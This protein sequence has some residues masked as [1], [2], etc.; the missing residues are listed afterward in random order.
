MT[1]GNGL[2]CV[3]TRH[4]ASYSPDSACP[5]QPWMFSP[6]GQ[7]WLHG[8]RR[9]RYTGR[10]VR[11]VPVWLARLEPGSSVM[12]KGLRIDE[13]VL[14]DVAI[15]HLL[16]AGNGLGVERWSKQM[17]KAAL[18]LEVRLD[19]Q[20]P[21]DL[22]DAH[23]LAVLGLE[24]REDPGLLRKARNM[25]RLVGGVAPAERARDKN[26]QITR[27]AEFHRAPHLGFE[28]AQLGDGCGGDVRNAVRH[29]DPG[30][31]LSLTEG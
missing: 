8:G 11:Q 31:V 16:D 14:S 26:V 30:N 23:H 3:S 29:G 7:A 15:G 4:A 17:R 20:A 2:S 1:A 12:A 13:P 28:V 27:A 9:S 19:R 10:S 21:A 25:H 5:S 18:R 24:H 22:G 6:A